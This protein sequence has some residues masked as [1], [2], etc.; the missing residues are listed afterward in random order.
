MDTKI[1]LDLLESA[2]ITA[3]ADYGD[4]LTYSDEAEEKCVEVW[5]RHILTTPSEL[6]P[7][8]LDAVIDALS[9]DD[10][11]TE[12]AKNFAVAM[13]DLKVIQ[14]CGYSSPGVPLAYA[15]SVNLSLASAMSRIV[16]GVHK[17]ITA[18]LEASKEDDLCDIANYVRDMERERHDD[19]LYEMARDES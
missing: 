4:G 15:N 16:L 2:D 6:K 11:L 19:M 3:T 17:S 1:L 8:L 10:Q 7:F 13:A 12:V 18:T 5:R 9:V 14:D